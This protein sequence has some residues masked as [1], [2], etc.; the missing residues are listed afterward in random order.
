MLIKPPKKH[1]LSLGIVNM[2]V[3]QIVNNDSE[4]YRKNY[5]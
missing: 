4:Y 5:F 2:V 1:L 3:N